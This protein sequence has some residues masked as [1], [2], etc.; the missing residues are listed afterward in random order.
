MSLD[1]VEQSELILSELRQ[2]LRNL[3]TVTELSS[4]IL[5]NVVDTGIASVLLECLEQVEL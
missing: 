1:P 2:Y 4:H 5:Y 3:V